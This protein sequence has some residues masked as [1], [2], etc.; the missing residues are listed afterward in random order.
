MNGY[1]YTP[2]VKGPE[3]LICVLVAP[4]AE[5]AGEGAS[6]WVLCGLHAPLK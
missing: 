3:K 4:K 2:V 1:L 5:Q 6:V